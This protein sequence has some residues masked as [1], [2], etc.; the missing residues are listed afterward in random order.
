MGIND[1]VDWFAFADGVWVPSG[2]LVGP[3]QMF[4]GYVPMSLDEAWKARSWALEFVGHSFLAALD[5]HEEPMVTFALDCLPILRGSP[6]VS[7]ATREGPDGQQAGR[8]CAAP[9]GEPF[10]EIAPSLAALTATTITGL[11]SGELVVGEWGEIWDAAYAPDC[12][13]RHLRIAFRAGTLTAY[14][15]G[16]STRLSEALGAFADLVTQWGPVT[17]TGEPEGFVSGNNSLEPQQIQE[18]VRLLRWFGVPNDQISTEIV[19][20]ESPHSAHTVVARVAI[21]TPPYATRHRRA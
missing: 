8:L 4:P 14:N 3:A 15:D 9:W 20:P 12:T 11:R 19:E 1:L 5:R 6:M 2:V 13:E 16:S 21:P 10:S 18:V 17:V 7:M